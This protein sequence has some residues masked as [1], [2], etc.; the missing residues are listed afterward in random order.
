M[1]EAKLINFSFL[2][3]R[4]RT[5]SYALTKMVTL[6]KGIACLGPKPRTIMKIGTK[7]PPPPRPPISIEGIRSMFK[8]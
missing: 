4:P 3:A 7:I 1:I 6:L 5:G 2:L 8:R